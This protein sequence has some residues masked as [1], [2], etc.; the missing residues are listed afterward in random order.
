[1]DE[2]EDEGY[3]QRAREAVSV[4]DTPGETREEQEEGEEVCKGGVGTVPCVLR[5]FMV[6][7]GPKHLL[8]RY[9]QARHLPYGHLE[10]HLGELEQSLEEARHSDAFVSTRGCCAAEIRGPARGPWKG[11]VRVHRCCRG[12]EACELRRCWMRSG[13]DLGR[14]TAVLPGFKE[15]VW[16]RRGTMRGV[17]PAQNRIA[18]GEANVL[19]E[20]S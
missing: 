7:Y 3:S 9:Y 1:M 17:E 5:L 12:C 8:W 14:C 6:V 2:D 16:A 11:D 4:C 15:Q 20:C 18:R 19:R 10:V 13:G